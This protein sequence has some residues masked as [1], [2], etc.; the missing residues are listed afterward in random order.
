LAEADAGE[1]SGEAADHS[2]E[3]VGGFD[4]EQDE[5]AGLMD[6]GGMDLHEG[7][8]TGAGGVEGAEQREIVAAGQVA[9][10]EAHGGERER[11]L[12]PPDVFFVE[13][14]FAGGVAVFVDAGDG[15]VA[16][17]KFGRDFGGVEDGDIGGEFFVEEA[18]EL[19]RGEGSAG[20]GF[21]VGDLAGGVDAGVGTTGAHDVG[22]EAEDLFGCFAEFIG[23]GAGVGLFLPP[24]I[25]GAVVFESEFPGFQGSGL[26]EEKIYMCVCPHGS[27]K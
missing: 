2:P 5:V 3:K 25:A 27:G 12:D 19:F 24:G 15:V 9:G 21:E 18:D 22:A 26:Q 10:G 6:G 4:L 1:G 11:L 14:G 23:D 16:G 8:L 7:G 13:G 20:L 17:V